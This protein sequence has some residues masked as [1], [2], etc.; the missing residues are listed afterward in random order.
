VPVGVGDEEIVGAVKVVVEPRVDFYPALRASELR[1]AEVVHVQ[2]DC[3]RVDEL[4]V[5][6]LLPASPAA[7]GFVV[8]EQVEIKFPE[9][10]ARTLLVCV[11]KVRPRDMRADTGMVQVVVA[12]DCLLDCA[13]SLLPRKLGN[14]HRVELRPRRKMPVA[15]V[16]VRLGADFPETKSVREY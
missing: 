2:A 3:R 13:Q 1:P 15:L 5:F 9:D 16:R 6:L 4:Q 12:R 10:F 7:E 8:S 11:G 14:H